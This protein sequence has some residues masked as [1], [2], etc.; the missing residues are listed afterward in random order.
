MC[1]EYQSF[2]RLATPHR[3]L[4]SRVPEGVTS[5]GDLEQEGGSPVSEP[6][7][8]GIGPDALWDHTHK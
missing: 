5:G 1:V 2:G 7:L 3:S 8:V 6:L 4:S